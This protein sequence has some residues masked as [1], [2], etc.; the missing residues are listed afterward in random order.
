MSK[1][2]MGSSIDDFLKEEGSWCGALRHLRPLYIGPAIQV[3]FTPASS[4]GAS[5]LC[6][7]FFNSAILQGEASIA[8]NNSGNSNITSPC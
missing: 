7:V 4:V 1:K 3:A 8:T 2:N 6:G 5:Q